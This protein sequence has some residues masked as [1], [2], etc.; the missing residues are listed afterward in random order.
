MFYLQKREKIE[1][2]WETWQEI[3][4]ESGKEKE[5]NKNIATY[6]SEL[7]KC[8]RFGTIDIDLVLVFWAIK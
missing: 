7:L 4:R 2:E 8:F 1:N 3:E 5:I 6:F